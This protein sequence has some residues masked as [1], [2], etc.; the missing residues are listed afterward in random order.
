MVIGGWV[1]GDA[2]YDNDLDEIEFLDG[3]VKE[4]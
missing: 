2:A 4:K 3:L 1:L